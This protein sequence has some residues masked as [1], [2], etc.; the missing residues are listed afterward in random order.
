[1]AAYFTPKLAAHP[2]ESLRVVWLTAKNGVRVVRFIARGSVESCPVAVRDVLRVPVM[3]VCA[4]LVLGPRAEPP[5]R[6]SEAEL[7]RSR[8]SEYRAPRAHG[9][10]DR[11]HP[12]EVG[13]DDAV[14]DV[15]SRSGQQDA[16]MLLAAP[17]SIDAPDVWLAT[18][19]LERGAKLVFEQ[20]RRRLPVCTPPASATLRITHRAW[21]SSI[22]TRAP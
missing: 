4:G 8:D 9:V 20:T 22:F 2:F 17:G 6:R 16:S 10:P 3:N 21:A 1:M 13:D 19:Q 15:V 18:D 14:V 11:D 7:R 12:H 5:E